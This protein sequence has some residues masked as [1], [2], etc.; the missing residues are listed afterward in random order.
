MYSMVLMMALS[1]SASTPASCH[2]YNGCSGGYACN[3]YACNG[4]RHGCHGFF[5]GLFNGHG[6]AGYACNGGCNG[7]NGYRHG[8]HGLFGGL[9]GGW[10]NGCNGGC[11]GYRHGCHGCA[12]AGCTGGHPPA[13]PPAEKKPGAAPAKPAAPAGA[14]KVEKKEEAR[15][16][17]PARLLV[18]L[19]A[20]AKLTI[21][22]VVTT[23]TSTTRL[24]VTPELAPGKDYI[25]TLKAEVT[26]DGK[27]ETVIKQVTVRAGMTTETTLEIPVA[28]ASK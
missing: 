13:L 20:E 11:Y 10:R 5:G 15:V 14:P 1:T 21:D 8:C 22:D 18:N 7:C 19:P 16:P 27:S 26:R 9:F 3:G 25:Y 2:G 6:C 12:G 4:Y 17:T 24:F 23:S 28:T